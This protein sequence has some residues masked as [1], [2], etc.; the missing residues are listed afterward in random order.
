MVVVEVLFNNKNTFDE[1]TGDELANKKDSD[2]RCVWYS[3]KSN[4]YEEAWLSC[5]SLKKI[6][7]A[8][9][10]DDALFKPNIL[11]VLKTLPLELRKKKSS[12]TIDGYGNYK[13]SVNV[14][15]LLSFVGPVMQI[16]SVKKKRR[17]SAKV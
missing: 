17:Q 5:K 7:S 15:S 6:Q 12:L 2:C 14:T 10:T 4:Q 8:Q 13:E 9:A 3:T 1:I 11:V 16:I